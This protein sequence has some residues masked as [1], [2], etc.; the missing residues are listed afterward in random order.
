MITVVH[1]LKFAT[2]PI[3][4]TDGEDGGRAG[5]SPSPNMYDDDDDDDDL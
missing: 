5:Q 4:L 3:N 2:H 1:A